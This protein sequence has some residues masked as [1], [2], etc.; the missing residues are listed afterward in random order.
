MNN[1]KNQNSDNESEE[2]V[3]L[4]AQAQLRLHAYILALVGRP[5]DADDLLQETNVILWRKRHTFQPGTNF[6]AWAFKI[7]QLQ[8]LAHR[9][10]HHRSKV[11]FDAEL[12]NQI[13]D[14]AN[15]ESKHYDQRAD[16]LLTCLKKLPEEQRLLI[17]R[18]Y[19]PDVAVH[20]LADEMGKTA[21]AVSESLR[22]IRETLRQCIER[23]LASEVRS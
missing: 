14:I 2:H 23:A 18:R 7:A 3:R 20:S 1:N 15:E 22:R 21:N 9:S 16:A 12:I 13:A 19:Q 4:I 6:F 11:Q 10:K 8:V 17:T 5:S